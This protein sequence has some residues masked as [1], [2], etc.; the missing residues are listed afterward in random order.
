MLAC[1]LRW[2]AAVE[3]QTRWVSLV[4]EQHHLLMFFHF[5]CPTC[6]LV[7][8]TLEENLLRDDPMM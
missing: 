2:V 3:E 6:G 1:H 5:R 8:L 4:M 7:H